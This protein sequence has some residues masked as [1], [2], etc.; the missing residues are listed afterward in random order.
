MQSSKISEDASEIIYH[1]TPQTI[2]LKT[3]SSPDIHMIHLGV[4]AHQL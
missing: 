4:G 3:Q 1:N 2:T